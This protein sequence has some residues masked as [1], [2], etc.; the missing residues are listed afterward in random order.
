MSVGCWL[1]FQYQLR[2][3][4]RLQSPI[5]NQLDFVPD[6]VVTTEQPCLCFVLSVPSLRRCICRSLTDTSLFGSTLGQIFAKLL[7]MSQHSPLRVAYLHCGK[8][9][10]CLH[11]GYDRSKGVR[12]VI[13]PRRNARHVPHAVN[14]GRSSPKLSV[15]ETCAQ[16]GS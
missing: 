15:P 3:C 16:R 4:Q 5:A 12:G 13:D 2:R 11:H 10:E 1:Q 14:C 9:R 8:A 7:V 6:Q